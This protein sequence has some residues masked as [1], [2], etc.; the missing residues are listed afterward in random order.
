MIKEI[1][2]EKACVFEGCDS[3]D[4][5]KVYKEDGKYNA[6]CYSCNRFDQDPYKTNEVPTPVQQT[7]TQSNFVEEYDT[8]PVRAIT[9]RGISYSTAEHYG[10]KVGVSTTDGDTPVYHLYPRHS[11]GEL[12]GFKKKTVKDKK[13]TCVG[14]SKN[15]DLFGINLIKPKGKKLWIT[16]GELDCLSL[17][18][19][20]K[21]N[22]TYQDLNPAVLSL[23][24]G[25]TSATKAITLNLEIL[26]QYDEII[27]VFDNDAPGI[28]ATEEVCKI[29]AGKVHTVKIPKPFKDPND[30]LLAGKGND[31]K[32]LALTHARKYHPDGIV[33][34]KDCWERYK[35]IQ[36]TPRYPYPPTMPLLQ[37]K[38][39]GVGQGS[40]TIITSGSGCG[41]TQF[42][43]ELEYWFYKSTD[44]KIASIKLEE[45]IGDTIGG[46]I[47]IDLNKRIQLPEVTVDEEEEKESFKDLFES[48]RFTLYDFFGGMDDSTLFTKLRYLAAS[49]NRFIFLDHLSIIISEFASQGDERQRI[50]T[51]MTGLAR[52]VKETGTC[53]FLVVHLRKT[54][55]GS[56]TFEEGAAPTL[57]ALR[58]S[59][60][61]KQLTW[62]V[63][64]LARNQQHKDKYCA[65]TTELIGLKSRFTGRTGVADYLHFDDKTGRMINVPRPENY[66]PVKGKGSFGS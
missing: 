7:T 1:V 54:D 8:H 47:A 18:Q 6:Y 27:L 63:I 62:D 52:F 64:A 32:W 10:V 41:K 15:V 33:N 3:S 19:A 36:Q 9:D 22:S 38:L 37:E 43:R 40:I 12:V 48:D 34:A 42:T 55:Q 2:E 53:L 50:D 30:M 24:D 35:T 26:L 29:L 28:T 4:A 17:F 23:P 31:L 16:E 56:N 21:E 25:C 46:L 51:I 39:Q 61:L 59:S 60:T 13:F 66:R 65:N 14:K 45:D 49:G 58:G 57:D 20:L 5:Y 11:K 44:E